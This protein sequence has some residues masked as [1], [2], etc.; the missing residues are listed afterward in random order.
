MTCVLKS[1]VFLYVILLCV[2]RICCHHTWAFKEV[3]RPGLSRLI[4]TLPLGFQGKHEMKEFSKEYGVVV[5]FEQ[6][7]Y[8]NGLFEGFKGWD[9]INE[10]YGATN[11]T[12]IVRVEFER[13][14]LKENR[15]KKHFD[16]FWLPGSI[17]VE[18]NIRH[19]QVYGTNLTLAK[20]RNQSH[21]DIWV[22]PRCFLRHHGISRIHRVS[23]SMKLT[24]K[25]IRW[26][27]KINYGQVEGY[28]P[29]EVIEISKS[30]AS[31]VPGILCAWVHPDI[32]PTYETF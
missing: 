29:R 13:H 20:S 32:D 28:G 22:E 5:S 7:V 27:A 31:S 21:V 6:P 10:K 15:I 8:S 2:H 1:L 17:Y 30:M 12:F 16:R 4:A 26:L 14:N 19:K 11:T 24:V 3:S 18:R 25:Q 23:K 9:E